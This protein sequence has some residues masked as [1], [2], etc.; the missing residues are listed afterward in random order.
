MA[1]SSRIAGPGDLKV[2]WERGD[3]VERIYFFKACERRLI[4]VL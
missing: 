3:A 4:T 2:F 1:V